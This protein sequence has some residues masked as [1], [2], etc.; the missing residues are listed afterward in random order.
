MGRIDQ[1]MRRAQQNG[2]A[3]EF[4]PIPTDA[5]MAALAAEPFPEEGARVPDAQKVSYRAD[6]GSEAARTQRAALLRFL[7]K[8]RAARPRD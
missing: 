3:T 7:A 8:V 6:R 5:D 4:D 2:V 1:A